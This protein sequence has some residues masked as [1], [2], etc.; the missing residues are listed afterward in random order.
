VQVWLN[1]VD[2]RCIK[3]TCKGGDWTGFSGKIKK[4]M[5]N[6]KVLIFAKVH[7]SPPSLNLI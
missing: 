4:K 3:C 6:T 1:S 5:N 7:F 2:V